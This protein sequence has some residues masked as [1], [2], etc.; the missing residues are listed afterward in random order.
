MIAS[1]LGAC[2]PRSDALASFSA[3][4]NLP[5]RFANRS[6]CDAL[7]HSL[8]SRLVM[9]RNE[10][11]LFLLADEISFANNR[12]SF[13][14]VFLLRF[15][16]SIG[17]CFGIIPAPGSFAASALPVPRRKSSEQHEDCRVP[18]TMQPLAWGAVSARFVGAPITRAETEREKHVS[19]S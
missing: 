9:A 4:K 13:V 11:L 1:N 6:S 2:F 16:P 10:N 3:L 18:P 17:R 8:A 19:D 14:L 7:I 5:R 15:A 12:L